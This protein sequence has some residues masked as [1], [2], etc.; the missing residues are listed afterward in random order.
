MTAEQTD[1]GTS[2]LLPQAATSRKSFQLAIK[3]G[4]FVI[5]ETSG[6]GAKK[7]MTASQRPKGLQT[8]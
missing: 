6:F 3:S 1:C 2:L 4:A 7:S 5:K 8:A